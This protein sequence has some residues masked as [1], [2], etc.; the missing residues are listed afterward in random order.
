VTLRQL[1][2][3]PRVRGVAVGA[4]VDGSKWD[5]T[6][7]AHAH[8]GPPSSRSR[9]VGW[10][11]I[12]KPAD[13]LNSEILIEELAHLVADTDGIHDRAFRRTRGVIR[14]RNAARR[15]AQ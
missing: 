5:P 7:R 3:H 1:L 6:H 2:A 11:C 9:F 15:R 13:L 4:C 12:E 14:R 10:I 8:D